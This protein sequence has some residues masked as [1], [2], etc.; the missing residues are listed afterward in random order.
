MPSDMNLPFPEKER[1]ANNHGKKPKERENPNLYALS[2]WFY[3]F[4]LIRTSYA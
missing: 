3:L 4:E 2:L 1:C